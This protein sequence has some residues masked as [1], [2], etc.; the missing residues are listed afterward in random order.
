MIEDGYAWGY[1]GE[2]KI[3]DFAA[4]SEARKS[5]YYFTMP[6]LV[7]QI[8]QELKHELNGS[9]CIGTL[10]KKYDCSI[11]FSTYLLQLI[12]HEIMENPSRLLF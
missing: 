4:L 1:M 9:R 12:Q 11:Y 8:L 10:T 6:A 5:R 2:T 3:K 7:H